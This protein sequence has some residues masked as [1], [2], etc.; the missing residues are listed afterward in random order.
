MSWYVPDDPAE[1]AKLPW[2]S[3]MRI[4]MARNAAERDSHSCVLPGTIMINESTGEV[5]IWLSTGS[6]GVRRDS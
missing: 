1:T 4:N 2:E 5:T 3:Q 6:S